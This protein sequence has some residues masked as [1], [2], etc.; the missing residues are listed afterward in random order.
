MR[1]VFDD[2]ELEP[3]KPRHDT[4]LTLG[5]GML[6][7]IFVVL[8][9][10]CGV[11]FIL[12]YNMGRRG[13][14]Q[15]L[16]AVQSAAGALTSSHVD[17]ARAKPSAIGQ[18]ANLAPKQSTVV[19]PVPD[20]VSSGSST[21]PAAGSPSAQPAAVAPSPAAQSQFSAAQVRPALP[22]PATASQ[23]A[24]SVTGAGGPNVQPALASAAALMV[25]IAA[26]SHVEDAQVLMNA[27]RR[28]GYAVSARR[29]AG[30]GL[31]HVRIG[32]F[33]SRDEANQWR[34]KLLNDGYNAIVQ[35]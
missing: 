24:Q 16:A 22:P 8:L 20:S 27:L 1:S 3:A 26:V 6:L 33:S 25:Q 5:S 11:F 4:E 30:D 12:G 29:D 2:E 21:N 7:G 10:I 13:S 32:P 23:P 9:L 15:P 31:I 19:G 14:P 17:N 18:A 28:R 34:M 35:P